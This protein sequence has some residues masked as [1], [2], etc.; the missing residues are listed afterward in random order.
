MVMKRLLIIVM[1]MFVGAAGYLVSQHQMEETEIARE[2][3][4]MRKGAEQFT[5]SLKFSDKPV[6]WG[7][8][9]SASPSPDPSPGEKKEKGQ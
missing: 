9:P 4:S 2:A 5:K 3:E 7:D 8:E 1:V 6:Y